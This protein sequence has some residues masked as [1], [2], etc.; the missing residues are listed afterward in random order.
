MRICHK[1]ASAILLFLNGILGANGGLEEHG[2]QGFSANIQIDFSGHANL[3][4]CV[5]PE[6]MAGHQIVVHGALFHANL[7]PGLSENI[8]LATEERMHGFIRV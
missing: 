6:Q 8:L 2:H 5:F 4:C 7:I 1:V 3:V